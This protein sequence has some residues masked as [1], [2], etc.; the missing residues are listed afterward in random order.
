M[1]DRQG[2]RKTA[3]E[4]AAA[5]DFLDSVY[6]RVIAER[7]KPKPTTDLYFEAH[8]TIEPLGDDAVLRSRVEDLGKSLDFRMATFLL[9]KDNQVPDDFF[10]A[11]STDYENILGQTEMMVRYLQEYGVV[12]KRWKIENTLVDVKL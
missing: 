1:S 4:H 10:S 9:K 3:S 2:I 12:V 5:E 8:V 6:A 7:E 11:R